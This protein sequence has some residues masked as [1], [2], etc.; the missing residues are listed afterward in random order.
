MQTVFE[1]LRTGETFKFEEKGP[2]FV[3]GRG[4]YRKHDDPTDESLYV[5]Q[6]YKAVIR[7]FLIKKDEE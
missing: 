7:V 4:G 5:C 3:K 1:R 6:S 2:T